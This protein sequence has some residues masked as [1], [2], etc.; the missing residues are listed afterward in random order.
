MV[1]NKI[2][3]CGD[4][5]SPGAGPEDIGGRSLTAVRLSALTGDGMDALREHLCAAAGY[6]AGGEGSF[7]ARRRHI[8]ALEAARA[9]FDAGVRRLES[10]RAG[11]LFAEEL[12]LAQQ[13][14]GEITGEVTSDDLLGRIFGSFCIGK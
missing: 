14:L 9:A 5:L 6:D 10:E 11:E 3:V 13:A 8:L 12:R 7:S 1:V 4:A 2:D